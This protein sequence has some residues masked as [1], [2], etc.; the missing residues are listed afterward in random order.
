METNYID[1]TLEFISSKCYQLD[2]HDFFNEVSKFLAHLFDVDYV[3]IDK[4]ISDKKGFVQIESF[5]EFSIVDL[6][7]STL[8]LF[9]EF[10]SIPVILYCK[11]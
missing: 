11:I 1:K 2:D 4:C 8:F 9:Q 10:Q 7:F 6:L 5:F 3:I